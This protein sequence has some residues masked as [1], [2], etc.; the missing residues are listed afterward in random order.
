MKSLVPDECECAVC[1][2]NTGAADSEEA[3][4]FG[5]PDLDFRPP[6]ILGATLRLWVTECASCGYCA[7][8]LDTS[9]DGVEAIVTGEAF[10]TSVPTPRTS[11]KWRGNSTWRPSSPRRSGTPLPHSTT[12]CARRGSTMTKTTPFA[13]TRLD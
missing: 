7:P 6:P 3:N 4:P 2:H 8:K 11:R 13:H 9:Y 5:F 1:G 12:L 10:Q